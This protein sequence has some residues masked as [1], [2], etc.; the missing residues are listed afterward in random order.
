MTK[1]T[2]KAATENPLLKSNLKQLRLPTMLSEHEAGP[3]SGQCEP[4][5]PGV[6]TAIDGTGVG[7][8]SIE[9]FADPNPFR[10]FSSSEGTRFV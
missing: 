3:G 4:G 7:H 2:S 8:T 9:C 10:Q 6:S 5:L 1:K